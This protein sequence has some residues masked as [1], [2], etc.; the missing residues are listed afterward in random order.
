[1]PRFCQVGRGHRTFSGVWRTAVCNQIAALEILVHRTSSRRASGDG[2]FAAAL[3][4]QMAADADPSASARRLAA[5]TASPR[6]GQFRAVGGQNW[7]TASP[8][9][10]QF[11]SEL[12]MNGRP[13]GACA[14]A[15]STRV[16]TSGNL[17]FPY[18]GGHRVRSRYTG[19]RLAI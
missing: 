9:T 19:V 2:A 3:A 15:L 11:R 12:G 8:R 16:E 4:C 13:K 17:S 6:M 10:G 1:M 14:T 18:R 7:D 5:D